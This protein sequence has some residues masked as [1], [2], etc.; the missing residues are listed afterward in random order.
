MH[1]TQP[2][3][4]GKYNGKAVDYWNA[5]E[6]KK[7]VSSAGICTAAHNHVRVKDEPSSLIGR[8]GLAVGW[9]RFNCPSFACSVLVP[10]VGQFST[11]SLRLIACSLQQWM[12]SLQD[13][14]SKIM[15]EPREQFLA[16]R[17]LCTDGG[18]ARKKSKTNG[19]S[20]L[21]SGSYTDSLGKSTGAASRTSPEADSS[22][23]RSPQA[24]FFM[25]FPT[26]TRSL[27]K[28]EVDFLAP[29]PT[30]GTSRLVSACDWCKRH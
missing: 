5:C 10:F 11:T 13:T 16:L 1:R 23:P 2:A 14:S 19:S 27:G 28:A 20:I 30:I 9:Q 6:H 3:A 7:R 17:Y 25:H 12:N 8:K 29:K 18:I 24:A 22:K 26:S 15:A 21:R 4:Y